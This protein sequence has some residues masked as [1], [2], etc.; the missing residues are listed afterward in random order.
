[1]HI[2]NLVALLL[3]FPAEKLKQQKMTTE[4]NEQVQ[5]WRYEK[6]TEWLTIKEQSEE[7]GARWSL[8]KDI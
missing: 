4:D 8:N 6:N 2:K 5:R 3:V 1:M 7:I